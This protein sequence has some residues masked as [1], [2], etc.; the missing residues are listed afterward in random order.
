MSHLYFDSALVAGR[1]AHDVRI[2]V[3]SDGSISSVEEDGSPKG[4]SRIPGVAVPGVPNVHSH[5]FQRAMAGLTERGSTGGDTFWSWRERMYAFL[6]RLGPEEVGA[7]AA[8][9]YSEMLRHGFTAVTEFHYLRNDVGGGVFADPVEMGRRLLDAAG[10]A[11][12]GMTLLPT[13]Y[14]QS[15]FGG[16]AATPAQARFVASV[17]ELVGDVAVL[18]AATDGMDARTGLAL[19]SLRAVTPKELAV[20]VEAVRGIDT[21]APVHIHVAEQTREVDA[22]VAWSGMRPVEWLLDH[23]PV[24]EGWCLVHATHMTESEMVS[25]AASGAVVGLCPTTEA[26]LGDGLFTLSDFIAQGGAWAVGTDSHVGVSPV[27]ELRTLEYGQ[28]LNHRARNVVVGRHALSSGRALLDAAWAGGS[29]A[30]ARSLGSIAPGMRAD[31]VVLD[32][33]HPVLVGREGDEILDSWI[34]SGDDTPVRDV[35][36]GGRWVVQGGRHLEQESIATRYRAAV[37]RIGP[38]TPQLAMDLDE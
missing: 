36:V 33:E 38:S 7:V 28:R 13:L 27:G 10:R 31:L 24:D 21:S 14:R 29:R 15:D 26:N 32:A 9:L 2:A 25:L 34:F 5:A 20:A 19:H 18:S 35:M 23:A 12:I 11:G 37:G 8:Q 1:W 6:E 30:S 22:C 3:S 4:A 17:E 16:A